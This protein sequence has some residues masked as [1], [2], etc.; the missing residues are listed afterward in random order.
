M[1]PDLHPIREQLQFVR[2]RP[3]RAEDF[4]GNSEFIAHSRKVAGLEFAIDFQVSQQPE[5]HADAATLK[6]ATCLLNV[7]AARISVVRDDVA[8]ALADDETRNIV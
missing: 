8:A 2:L 3:R 4:H 5:T 6:P 1:V 7:D